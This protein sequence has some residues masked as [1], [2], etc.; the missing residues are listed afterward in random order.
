MD[1]YKIE[2][3]PNNLETVEKLGKM[4]KDCYWDHI[5]AKMMILIIYYNIFNLELIFYFISLNF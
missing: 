3:L 4:S 1:D 2:C 5:N